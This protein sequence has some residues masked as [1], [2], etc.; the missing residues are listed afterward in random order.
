MKNLVVT[1][2]LLAGIALAGPAHAQDQATAEKIA[3]FDIKASGIDQSLANNLADVVATYIG[4]MP[5]F[6]AITRNEVE[7]MVGL[8]TSSQ[9]SA[10]L[11]VSKLSGL[12]SLA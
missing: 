8:E 2:F 9:P 4:N 3:I 10:S 5:G 11:N 7:A 1:L 12:S 6:Q